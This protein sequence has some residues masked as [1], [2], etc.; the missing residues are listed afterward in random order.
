VT[1]GQFCLWVSE[2]CFTYLKKG[3]H[4]ILWSFQE[5]QNSCVTNMFS[6]KFTCSEIH[7][8]CPDIHLQWCCMFAM[9]K[10]LKDPFCRSH[11]VV[12]RNG[13]HP[14]KLQNQQLH[15]M[16]QSVSRILTNKAR[17]LFS[18]QF[19]PLSTTRKFKQIKLVESVKRSVQIFQDCFL[20]KSLL[21]KHCDDFD[22]CQRY[23]LLG[24]EEPRISLI[25]GLRDKILKL[26]FWWRAY[27]FI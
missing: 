12:V 9:L 25:P 8:I 19:Q 20:N 6:S 18:S 2:F 7:W 21:I 27:S 26:S 11:F 10:N 17:W 15:K 24:F 14:K 1:R 3:I 23:C 16:L 22:C 4:R 5:F 13:I